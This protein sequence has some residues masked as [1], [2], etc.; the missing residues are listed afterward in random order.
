LYFGAILLVNYCWKMKV[1]SVDGTLTMPLI[2]TVTQTLHRLY[3]DERTHIYLSKWTQHWHSM[4]ITVRWAEQQAVGAS[5]S[6]FS[7][8]ASVVISSEV[9]FH[10][11]ITVPTQFR[12]ISHHEWIS[13]CVLRKPCSKRW[14]VTSDKNIAVQMIKTGCSPWLKWHG[15]WYLNTLFP[16]LYIHICHMVTLQRQKYGVL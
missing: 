16:T 10:L 8:C 1:H 2:L 11:P 13:R 7:L 12:A 4:E 3:G 5:F 6:S 14:T 9:T 15:N